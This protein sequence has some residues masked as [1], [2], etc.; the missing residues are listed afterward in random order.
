VRRRAAYVAGNLALTELTAALIATAR[1]DA[2]DDQR[3]AVF[4]ALGE[5]RAPDAFADTVEL[6]RKLD[7]AAGPRVIVAALRALSSIVGAHPSLPLDLGPLAAK[8]SGYLGHADALVREAAVRIAGLARGAVSPPAVVKLVGD[9]SPRVRAEA[10][11]ALGRLGARDAEPLL[12]AAFQDADPA[13]HE[14]AALA[15]IELGGRRALEEVVGYVAGDGDDQARAHVAAH[16][17]IAPGEAAHFLPRLDAALARLGP[18]DDAYEPLLAAKLELLEARAGGAAS[19]GDVDAAIVGAFPSFEHFIKLKGFDTLVKSV[20]TAEALYRSTVEP[21]RRRSVAADRLV[22]EGARELRPRLAGP[23]AVDGAARADRAVR[24]RRSGRRRLGHGYQRYVGDRWKDHVEMG[25]AKVEVPARSLP[26]TLRDFQDHKRKRL[27][28]PLS[29]TEWARLMVFF[30]VD[31]ASGVKNLFKLPAKSGDQI[32][33]LAHRL[34]TLAAVRNLVTHRAAA[35][36][37]TLDAFRKSYYLSFEDLAQ[38]A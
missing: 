13:I 33:R 31:H 26:N 8:A 12:I 20:R 11:T 14:R 22:D 19:P 37:A 34:H 18:D 10:F 16:L 30:A 27:D 4:V 17:T 29:V 21:G 1:G 15:L 23:A 36:G 35:S 25:T 7:G 6:A 38:M 3:I 28:S 24:L 5:L 9:G 32:I 2:D